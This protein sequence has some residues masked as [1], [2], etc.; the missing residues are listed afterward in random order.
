MLGFEIDGPTD[1]FPDKNNVVLN[2]FMTES[3][4]KKGHNS[5]AYHSGRWT[6]VAKELLSCF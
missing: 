2:S 5:I 3:M 4:V 1:V 6:A